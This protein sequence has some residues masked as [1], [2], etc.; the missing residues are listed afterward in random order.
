MI[1]KTFKR[2][3]NKSQ[4]ELHLKDNT[5]FL[6]EIKESDKKIDLFFFSPPYNIGS[7]SPAI[8]T[9]RKNGGYDAK[10]FRGIT[11]YDDKLDENEYQLNQIHI[12]N[13]CNT[14]IPTHGVVVY[15]HKN[16]HRNGKLISPLQWIFK[17]DLELFDELIWDRGST[18]QNGR[19]HA[20]QIDERLYIL[21]KKA[22]EPYY[23]PKYV[24]KNILENI[25]TILKI[26]PQKENLHNAAFPLQLAEM[27]V[28]IYSPPRGL[29]S[30]IYSGSGTTMLAAF[31]KGRD[32]LGCEKLQKY[33]DL[34]VK[35]LEPFYNKKYAY[36][37]SY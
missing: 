15:N 21:K 12:L 34:S 10:S 35:R 13:I 29:V 24:G 19:S 25:T 17:S 14:L 16:R 26:S 27:I 37:Y 7:S 18:H 33:F 5:N 30:D 4:Y 20:R 6:S 9:N 11:D 3:I 36:E 32:F 28:D 1:M 22:G 23:R 31:N 8:I 2:R